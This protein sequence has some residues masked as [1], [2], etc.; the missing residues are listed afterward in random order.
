MT[1][2]K[3]VTFAKLLLCTMCALKCNVFDWG[4][5][6]TSKGGTGCQ[7]LLVQSGPASGLSKGLEQAK[8][9]VRR[10]CSGGHAPD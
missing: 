1:H 7:G 2:E 5:W 8:G 6:G 9:D 3:R 4:D 10:S